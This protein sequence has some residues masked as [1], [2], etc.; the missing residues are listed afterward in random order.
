MKSQQLEFLDKIRKGAKEISQYQIEYWQS[1]S[2]LA[3]WQFWAL[4]I[5]LILPL[6]ALFMVINKR[7]VLLIG[8]FGLNYHVWFAYTNKIGVGLG[9]WEYPYH[10]IPSLP[11]FSLDA[12]LVPVCFMLLYQWTLHRKK[13]I[14][15]YSIFLSAIFAFIFKPIM[16][17]FDFFRMFQGINYIHLFLFYMAFFVVSI[18]ITNLFVWLQ[19]KER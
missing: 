16:G 5:M 10:L 3:T 9:L 15:V 4:A 13:N 7:K 14:Y 1:F 8:F 19:R 17:S 2:N 18:L 6:I 12:S 11:S